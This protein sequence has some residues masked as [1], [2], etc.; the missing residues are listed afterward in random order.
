MALGLDPRFDLTQALWLITGVAGADPA[1]ASLAS[2]VLPEIIVDGSLTHELDA[3]EI[4]PHWPDGFVPI[5]KSEP[6]E[7][8]RQPRFN[9][10]DGLVFRLSP[11]LI[12]WAHHIASIV[13]LLDTENI[14]ARR[15]QFAA[16]A[17]LLPPHVLRG[18]ELA[19]STFWHGALLRERARRW[20]H[21]Q[22]DGAATYT[23][24]A[25]EDAGILQALTQLAAAGRIDFQ[26]VLIARG[27]SNFDGPREGITAAQSL[28]ET[29]VATYSAYLPALENAWRVGHHLLHQWLKTKA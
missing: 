12:G 20:V 7:L 15:A 3:R 13:E 19:T 27:I 6:Y 8:P 2:V 22:T 10:D 23:L 4:P 16:P 29:K 18:D 26:R 25:M 11:A 1:R 5:G 21:Y 24:T 9:L 17:A 14:A 28:A